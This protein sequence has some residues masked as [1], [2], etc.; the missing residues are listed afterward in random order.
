MS[1]HVHLEP[2]TQLCV[3]CTLSPWFVPECWKHWDYWAWSVHQ[4]QNVASVLGQRNRRK[5]EFGVCRNQPDDGWT[6]KSN[7]RQWGNSDVDPR[8]SVLLLEPWDQRG[9]KTAYQ[10]AH[11]EGGSLAQARPRGK[12]SY[13]WRCHL[14]QRETGRDTWLLPAPTLQSQHF[15]LVEPPQ[16]QNVGN[17]KSKT[18]SSTAGARRGYRRSQWMTSMEPDAFL[19]SSGNTCHWFSL[20]RNKMQCFKNNIFSISG[21]RM[22]CCK[23]WYSL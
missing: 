4:M 23:N 12:R 10:L 14:K 20:V 22:L 5:G 9:T 11:K 3:R 21:I 7:K 16:Q 6:E 18:Q 17:Q 15:P 13:C 1:S 19:H 2:L 8:K